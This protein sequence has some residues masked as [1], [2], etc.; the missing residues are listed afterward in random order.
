MLKRYRDPVTVKTP[1]ETTD[2]GG[3]FARAWTT[4]FS[5]FARIKPASTWEAMT[6]MQQD[7]GTYY[8]LEMPYD[9]RLITHTIAFEWGDRFLIADG[10]PTDDP[11]K[12]DVKFTVWERAIVDD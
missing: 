12:R 4:L 8:T 5:G 1:S 7:G 2:A 9:A 10:P 11:L 6:A 3:G